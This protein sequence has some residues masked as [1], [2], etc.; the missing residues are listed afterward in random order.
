MIVYTLDCSTCR[1]LCKSTYVNKGYFSNSRPCEAFIFFSMKFTI[2]RLS[3]LIPTLH[4]WSSPM[5]PLL[6]SNRLLPLITTIYKS[7][8]KYKPANLWRFLRYVYATNE[9]ISSDYFKSTKRPKK[10]ILFWDNLRL[11]IFA[12]HLGVFTIYFVYCFF[13]S[14]SF[15]EWYNS[16]FRLWNSWASHERR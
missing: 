1:D 16:C 12:N 13:F 11:K 7:S 15:L 6:V 8:T 9:A 3:P 2:P 5:A 14:H 4:S 10:F